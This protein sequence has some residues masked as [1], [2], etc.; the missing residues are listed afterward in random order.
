MLTWGVVGLGL[1]GLARARAL[2][3]DPRAEVVLGFRGDLRAAGLKPARSLHHLFESVDAVAICTPDVTHPDLVRAALHEGCHVV[4]EF[5]LAG[6]TKVGRELFRRAAAANKVLH[7]EHIELLDGPSRLLQEAA[8]GR[9]VRGG[10][11]RFVGSRRRG[12]YGI[13][14][15][16][17]ARLHRLVHALGLPEAVRVDER[18]PRHMRGALCYPDQACVQLEFRQ[19]DDL[20]RRTELRLEFEDQVLEQRGG[21]VWRDGERLEL[22][23][24]EGLFVQDQRVA[25]ARILDGAPSY[26]DEARILD[27]LSLAD[28]LVRSSPGGGWETYRSASQR[29]AEETDD[30]AEGEDE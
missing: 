26:V 19:D 14:H 1:A 28:A 23:P 18:G 21:E 8:R 6:T 3:A 5:P 2:A 22:P 30:D 17:V 9:R 20:P 12:T 16:N 24:V 27:V 15:A 4:V 29:A 11:V 7:V 25:T 10:S 13:A